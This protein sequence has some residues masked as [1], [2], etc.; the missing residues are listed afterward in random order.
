MVAGN[1]NSNINQYHVIQT[2]T[3]ST[4]CTLLFK[5]NGHM[6]ILGYIRYV[7]TIRL[8]LVIARYVCR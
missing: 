2:V 6:D 5:E 3:L 8:I 7:M 1:M 4:I